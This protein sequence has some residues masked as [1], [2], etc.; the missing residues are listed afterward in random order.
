MQNLTILNN[1]KQQKYTF[2]CI[3]YKPA[4]LLLSRS[5]EGKIV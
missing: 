2:M 1:I 4:D 3:Q 5:A